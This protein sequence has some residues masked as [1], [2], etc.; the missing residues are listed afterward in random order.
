MNGYNM[1][2]NQQNPYNGIN[3]T[4]N[5]NMNPTQP[6]NNQMN[7]YNTQMSSSS[8]IQQPAYGTSSQ[9][10]N[11]TYANQTSMQNTT[12]VNPMA[13]VAN[14][15]KEEAMEEAL[16]HTNQYTP[17]EAP[18]QEILETPKNETNKSAYILIVVIVIIMAL[19]ILFLPQISKMF[20][21]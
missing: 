7:N 8:M 9:M 3:N 13:A 21:W 19:F 5:S 16:S 11:N 4:Q 20:G 6:V 17:F 15:N 18:K 1:N 2:N 14:L 12:N 10:P